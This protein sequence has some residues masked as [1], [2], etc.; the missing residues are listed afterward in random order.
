MARLWREMDTIAAMVR[1][2]ARTTIV[3]SSDD[4][5]EEEEFEDE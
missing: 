5:G 3:E 2:Q 4:D 1:E